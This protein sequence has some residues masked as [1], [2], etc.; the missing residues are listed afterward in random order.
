VKVVNYLHLAGAAT[1]LLNSEALHEIEDMWQELRAAPVVSHPSAFWEDLCKINQQ[2]LDWGGEA[3]FKRTF[4]QNYFNFV[5]IAPDD[6]HMTRMRRLT[7]HVPAAAL[8]AYEIEDPDCDPEPTLGNP[9]RV[10]RN[11]RMISQDIVNSLRERN[12][13]LAAIEADDGTRFMAAELGAGY[14]RLGYLLLKTT[15]C[16]YFV[17]DI[18]P[19]LYVSQWYLTTYFP[20]RRAFR[21]RR[22]ERFEEVRLSFGCSDAA[23]RGS[24]VACARARQLVHRPYSRP[25]LRT[26]AI[27]VLGCN[28]PGNSK[29]RMLCSGDM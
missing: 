22:F 23:F 15:Q 25:A 9:I 24:P 1:H 14:G 8:E 10:R 13:L 28:R 6:V 27:I 5:P 4:N 7:R 19:A 29:H 26:T 21:F 18:P 2:L 20:E 17:F 3:N 16:R 12:A 11:G